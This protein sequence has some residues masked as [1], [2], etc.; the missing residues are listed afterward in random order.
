MID[1]VYLAYS[2]AK[3]GYGIETV[4]NFLNSYKK[5]PAGIEHNLVIIAKNW[6]DKSLFTQLY[7]LAKENNAKLIDL[8][9][10]GLDFGAY[11]RVSKILKNEYIF[12]LGSNIEILTDKWLLYSYKAFE[13]DNQ[14]QIMGPMGSWEKG[15][16]GAKSFPNYHIRTCSFMINRKLFL[17]YAA[18]QKFP[19]TKEDTWKLEHGQQSLTK[20][21]LDKG[22]KAVIVD[23]E[24]KVFNPENWI[25]SMTYMHPDA[26][27]SYLSDKWARKY[28]EHDEHNRVALE[29]IIWGQNLTKYPKNI[30]KE[31]A[32]KINIFISYTKLIDVFSTNVF[33]PMFLCSENSKLKLDT[34][35]DNKDEHIAHKSKFYGELTGYYWIWKNYLPA[36]NSEY[37]GFCDYKHFLDFNIS[38]IN[39]SPFRPIFIVDFK[40]VFNEYTEENILDCIQGYDIVLPEQISFDTSVYEHYLKTFSKSDMD[41]TLNII[42]KLYPQYTVSINEFMSLNSIYAIGSFIMKKELLNAFMEWLFNILETLEKKIDLNNYL[43]NKDNIESVFFVERFFNIW[44]IHNIKTQN[45]KIKT[46]TSFFIYY[47]MKEYL[48]K[49]MEEI[50]SIA[51]KG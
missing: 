46:T 30:V 43:K 41:L 26:C 37:I 3:L 10:N 51:V 31:F 5:H 27:K 9:D 29:T 13:N 15:K 36:A 38:K 18:T 20:F 8:P 50:Q 44:L 34:F 33:H 28:Y 35:Q 4:E 47:D 11:F 21:V 39:N 49:C 19:K 40:N 6:T 1:V 7:N 48:A 42:K 12:F 22:Y 14:V 32:S 25:S 16:M 23:S 2:N 24:G 17:E 45:L